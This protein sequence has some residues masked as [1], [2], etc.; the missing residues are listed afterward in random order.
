MDGRNRICLRNVAENLKG[1][2][3]LR[4]VEEDKQVLLKYWAVDSIYTTRDGKN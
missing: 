1:R 3:D 2:G 4:H